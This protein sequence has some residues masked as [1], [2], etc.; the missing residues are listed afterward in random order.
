MNNYIRK[1]KKNTKALSPVVASIILIAV[2]VAVSVVVAAWM[3]G[4]T[5]G[6]MGNAEQVSVSNAV[7][8]ADNVL[9]LTVRNTGGATVTLDTATIDGTSVTLA[10]ASGYSLDVTKG[11]STQVTLTL[12]GSSTFTSGAQYE[13]RLTTTKGTTIVYTATYNPI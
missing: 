3:G 13:A 5:I 12:G 6:L 9:T 11:N 4:M 2:T 10:A 8:T 1:I 7:F